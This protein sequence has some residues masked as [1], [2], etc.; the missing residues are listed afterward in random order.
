M[1]TKGVHLSVPGCGYCLW[2][3]VPDGEP[4]KRKCLV[5]AGC[6]TIKI[7]L[8]PGEYQPVHWQQQNPCERGFP[9]NVSI[10]SIW[11][12]PAAVWDKV[13]WESSMYDQET[14]RSRDNTSIGGN[15][16]LWVENI[17]IKNCIHGASASLMGAAYTLGSEPGTQEN[18]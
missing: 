17:S 1:Q 10:G 7:C 6:G 14:Y 16:I 15:L 2:T 8:W 9:P 11:K 3:A 5:Q 18:N 4:I 13:R 12:S